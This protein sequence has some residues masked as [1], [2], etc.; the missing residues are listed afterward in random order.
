MLS[1]VLLDKRPLLIAGDFNFHIDDSCNKSAVKFLDTC[2]TFGLLQH[3]QEPT[4]SNGHWLDLM[5]TK[6]FNVTGLI[7]SPLSPSDHFFVSFSTKATTLP[8]PA[9]AV[10]WHRGTRSINK[11][12]LLS[13]L[14][15]S[16]FFSPA[17]QLSTQP[18]DLISSINFSL[19]MA[20][21]ELA[22]LR[23]T[24]SK[25]DRYRFFLSTRVKKLQRRKRQLERRFNKSGSAEAFNNFKIF[26]KHY[27][28]TVRRKKS[29]FF[30]KKS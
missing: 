2:T 7:V 29:S 22:P 28:A 30:Y 6:D 27:K 3:V 8:A 1:A 14:G 13:S 20:V 24:R 10:T 4:H 25:T 19:K 9:R 17:D 18:E 21:D 11:F 16:G 15:N 5:L 23:P 12:D 26:L